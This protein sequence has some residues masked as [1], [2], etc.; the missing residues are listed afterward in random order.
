MQGRRALPH[1][2]QEIWE[3]DLV[4]GPGP[5]KKMDVTKAYHPGTL[6][7][8]QVGAFTYII[9]SGL[10]D[11]GCIIY[12][13]LVL[14]MGWVSSPKFVCTF[15]ETLTDVVNTMVDTD[16]PVPS[17]GANFKIPETPPPLTC[18]T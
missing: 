10:G 17:Y 11:K 1:I 2:L 8:S 18:L 14:L 3:A 4:Q 12:I 7:P 15:L 13:D 9:P 16:L 6:Q 5:V